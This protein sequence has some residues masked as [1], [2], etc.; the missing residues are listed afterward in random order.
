MNV[1]S[2]RPYALAALFPAIALLTLI[3]S[4]SFEVRAAE[5]C[6]QLLMSRCETCHYVTRVC[7]KVER[8][9]RK[10]SWFGGSR[11]SWKRTV[12]NMVRQGAQLSK[13]EEKILVDCLSKPSEEV[14]SLCKLGR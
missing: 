6:T 3:F 1:P 11:G 12:R 13:E 8:E 4:P 7:Q 5:S 10:K 9:S 14:L 2:P